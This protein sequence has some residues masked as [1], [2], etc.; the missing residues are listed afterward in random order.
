MYAAFPHL[1]LAACPEAVS[2]YIAAAERCHRQKEE[3]K[4]DSR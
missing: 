4:K 2:R 1:Y 3:K